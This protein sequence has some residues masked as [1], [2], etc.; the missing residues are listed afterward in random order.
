VYWVTSKKDIQRASSGAMR[1]YLGHS[2]WSPGQLEQELKLGAWQVLPADPS[3]IFDANPETLWKRMLER[4][5]L[6]TASR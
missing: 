1:L 3:V 5:Q 2:G 4:T 6:R